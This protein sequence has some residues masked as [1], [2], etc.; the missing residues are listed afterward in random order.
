MVLP[1][2]WDW[3]GLQP[4]CMELGAGWHWVAHGGQ[5]T[6]KCLSGEKIKQW[7]KAWVGSSQAQCHHY[8]LLHGNLLWAGSVSAGQKS[9][10]DR[11]LH[12][13]RHEA[14]EE[15]Q[16]DNGDHTNGFSGCAPLTS[17]SRVARQQSAD[18]AS[19]ADQDHWEG[20]GK[21]YHER[22]IV[23]H[24]Q[25]L[26][27]L[28]PRRL[29]ALGF[30]CVVIK[31]L[32]SHQEGRGRKTDKQP[33]ACTH[34]PC[35]ALCH[36]PQVLHREDNGQETCDR[37][38]SHEVNTAVEVYIEGIGA[39][40]THE[41]P[42]LPLALVDIVENSQR[43]SHNTQQI[44]HSQVQHVDMKRR[45]LAVRSD[46]HGQGKAVPH[47]AQHGDERVRRGVN[48]VT[49]VI[50]RRAV[51]RVPRCTVRQIHRSICCNT[52]K[53][54]TRREEAW[55]GVQNRTTKLLNPKNM[56]E[57]P[58]TRCEVMNSTFS[59]NVS[60]CCAHSGGNWY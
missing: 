45:A 41:I 6:A 52:Y 35:A 57:E 59:L 5:A 50:D 10:V 17:S 22:Q 19:V 16:Q 40:A 9:Q 31:M 56:H 46:Q 1:S 24:D 49:E 39:D 47:Q 27:T 51:S 23:Q 54:L 33:D 38:G 2:L 15:G 3:D 34:Q 36:Q 28:A 53:L 48:L 11:A 21:A 25:F 42:L 13:V 30:V 44:R 8:R 7:I 58:E 20:Q 55:W 37:H 12:V 14:D 26:H 4:G 43:Q 29:K 18:Y 60:C 32:A